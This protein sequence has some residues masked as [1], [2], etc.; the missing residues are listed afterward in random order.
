[1]RVP[2][3]VVAALG[4][5]ALG[6]FAYGRTH[7]FD[8][9]VVE[10]AHAESPNAPPTAGEALEPVLG[11][12]EMGLTLL[13]ASPGEQ[14][15]EAWAFG[16]GEL[17]E[18]LGQ[19]GGWQAVS[20]PPGLEG[21]PASAEAAGARVTGDGGVLLRAGTEVVLRDPGDQP[22]LVS[23]P[24]ITPA[25]GAVQPAGVKQDSQASPPTEAKPPTG[26]TSPTE[27]KLPKEAAS[28]TEVKPPTGATPSAESTPAA[29]SFASGAYAAIDEA[30][31]HT[32]IL[33]AA[34]G[35]ATGF[36]VLHYDGTQWTKAPE[37]LALTKEQAEP[38][39]NFMPK[40]LACGPAGAG[41]LSTSA[42]NCWLLAAYGADQLAL[43]RR[44]A[45]NP[46]Q[47]D[48]SGFTWQPVERIRESL[49]G[50]A[51]PQAGHPTLAA[52]SEEAQMLT[53]T[54]QGVWVDFR[55]QL[56]GTSEPS[57][58]SELIAPAEDA[59]PPRALG[60]WCYPTGPGC[61][62]SLSGPLTGAY[63]SF[64]WPGGSAEDPGTRIVARPGESD[65][66]ELPGGAEGSFAATPAADSTSATFISPGKGWL[67]V[68]ADTSGSA[69]FQ[70][71]SQLLEVTPQPQG[72]RLQES[73]VPFRRPLLAVAQAPGSAPADPGA[74]AIAVGA[75]GEVG[76]YIAGEGW[77]TEV[78]DNSAG[79]VQR[80]TLRGVAWP[81]AD[82]AYAVG[83]H[84]AMWVW[85]AETGLWEP[86]PA[87]DPN[88]VGSLTAIAFSTV[89]PNLG[90]AVGKG[91]VLLRY[92]KTWEQEPLPEALQAV[93]FTSI[94]FAG[95]EA[96]AT[97]RYVAGEREAGGSPSMK[98][99][100]GT[101]MKVLP[102]WP[103]NRSSPR[104]LGC[105][106]EVQ[107]WLVPAP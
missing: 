56:P 75:E 53:V 61:A 26:V 77:S 21:K 43:F 24:E 38:K 33:L 58:V 98:D 66:L 100:A 67:D 36:Q 32:G 47:A 9:V 94:A 81:E 79:E 22:R 12:P 97:Y 27:V 62:K 19:E 69:D 3:G 17:V 71:Q 15:G 50:E 68:A 34:A 41:Q 11:L 1:M 59:T 86:D 92:G 7:L 106:T 54:A 88:F 102:R 85:R 4:V 89:D 82:R 55:A 64:A 29:P 107:L 70:G 72:D 18:H 51:P 76:R 83:D 84:G 93:N 13:G 87:R 37:P 45:A 35:G 57:Y 46:D 99:R 101:S 104:P 91:G 6:V 14:A 60:R 80:P 23:L 2:W 16:G 65:L 20:L 30:G 74:Q 42:E 10:Q 90:Y 44:T 52:L 5:A 31:G 28:P 48:P 49:L 63:S 39:A 95:S 40:R 78:L 96:L 105:P 103:V 73:P 25:S 8:Q